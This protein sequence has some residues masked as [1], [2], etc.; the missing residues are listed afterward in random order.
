MTAIGT[1]LLFASVAFAAERPE[2][3]LWTAGAPGSEGK[4]AK[5]LGEAPNQDHGYFKVT[6]VHK[7]SLTVYLPSAGMATGAAMIIAPG[8]GHR[9]LN[10]DQEGTYVA[11]YL[12]SIGVAG[13]VLKYR[14]AREP[15]STYGVETNALDDTQRAI[16]MVR[17]RAEEWRV[18]PARIG[19]MGF[20]AGGEL[21]TLA[22][23]RYDAGKPSAAD[24]IDR[25]SSR[26]DF[27]A[28]IY[29][30]IRAD[31]Y[32]IPKDMPPTF[33]LCADNDAGPSA[34]LAGLY[35]M[36]KA[37]KIQTE[38]HVYATGGHG[39]GINPNTKNQAP[40]ATTWQLRL[41][42]WLKTIGMLKL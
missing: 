35:P 26:P 23:T 40:V 19:V 33:M 8:G 6:E 42:D 22:A 30:G 24:A 9:F 17:S 1:L 18:N 20:S 2:V 41:G 15:G 16:R 11:E 31:K 25:V 36:L 27:D 5:E 28:L 21:A 29:P 7:P 38:L 32:T 4:T 14:L 34:A 13:F 3:L 10:Y 12:N 39:F 37:A